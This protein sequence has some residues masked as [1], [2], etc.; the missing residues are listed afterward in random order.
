MKQELTLEINR[1]KKLLKSLEDDGELTI[2]ERNTIMHHMGAVK[3]VLRD[4]GIN[5][6]FSK[7]RQRA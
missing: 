4:T 6:S 3:S 1:F 2:R 7:A 5:Q